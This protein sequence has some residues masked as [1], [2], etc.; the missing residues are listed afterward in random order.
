MK[1]VFDMKTII[2][3][4]SAVVAH[5]VLAIVFTSISRGARTEHLKAVDELKMDWNEQDREREKEQEK[6]LLAR[7]GVGK[8]ER[9]AF[10]PRLDIRL[11][12]QKLCQA[13]MPSDYLIDVTVDRFSEFNI[14]VDIGKMPETD[15]LAEQLREL[16]SVI[17]PDYLYQVIF[18]DEN[19]YWVIDT[20]QLKKVKNWKRAGNSEIIRYCFPS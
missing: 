15:K 10:D 11:T 2:V 6:E 4:I 16:F 18:T 12:Y 3:L 19:H 7:F 9:A 5:L 20:E 14:Y 8:T 17:G 13:V 1:N